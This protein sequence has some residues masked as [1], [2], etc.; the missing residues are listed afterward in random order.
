MKKLKRVFTIA[1]VLLAFTLTSNVNAQG[2]SGNGG[3]TSNNDG[4]YNDNSGST[5]T[6]GNSTNNNG[7]GGNSN[8]GNDAIP[9]DGGLSILLAGAAFF[10]IK[11]LRQK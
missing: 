4:Q 6:N 3:G 7:N 9:L 2:N 11:K 1:F 8:G 10:G 5:Q